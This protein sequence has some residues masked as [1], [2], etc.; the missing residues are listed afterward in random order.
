MYPEEGEDCGVV[1]GIEMAI[2]IDIRNNDSSKDVDYDEYNHRP[3]QHHC[4]EGK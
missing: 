1:G 4:A 3:D 2:G